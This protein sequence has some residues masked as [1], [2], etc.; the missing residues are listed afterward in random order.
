[1][2]ILYFA[3][4]ASNMESLA[5][6]REVTVMQRRA[7]NLGGEPVEF[8]FF[9]ETTFETFAQ[10]LTKHRPDI[11][12]L[13]LHGAQDGL[14]FN[15]DMG[16]TV[17]LEAEAFRNLLPF[18]QLPKLIL[19]NAC[20][21]ATIA[22][23]LSI[24]GVPAIGTSAPISNHAAIVSA[25]V[26]YD[27]LLSGASIERA[28]NAMASFVQTLE[29]GKTDFRLFGPHDLLVLPLYRP[30]QL[31]A[32][33]EGVVKP[34]PSQISAYIGMVGCPAGV[35]QICFFT[36]D[37]T[38][39]S[40]RKSLEAQMTE[41]VRDQ[42]RRGEIWSETAWSG[43]GDFR[44]AACAIAPDGQTYSASTLLSDALERYT[45][46]AVPKGDYFEHLANA[47]RFL[48][49]NACEGFNDWKPG[50]KGNKSTSS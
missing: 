44:F 10:E 7:L 14:W 18:E 34:K 13:T 5:L 47:T 26:L 8:I 36:D 37:P 2:K 41:I 28:Y 21:S 33:L 4:T 30:V 27:R 22:E 38:F 40:G 48:R 24:S 50:R 19:L 42:P 43:D 9:P 29:Q 3:S 16:D 11:L 39:I 6:E 17:K 12:H 31:V 46:L 1:M 35:S 49:D 32:R 23:A 15:T 45:T 25:S 20:A